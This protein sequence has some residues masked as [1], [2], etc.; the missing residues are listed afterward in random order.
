MVNR[1]ITIS[2]H[3]LAEE[4]L[5][6]DVPVGVVEA[7]LHEVLGLEVGEGS[8]LDTGGFLD[9]VEEDLLLD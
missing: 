5:A 6:V 7:R 4:L 2:K 1:L 9:L 8:Y 3:I